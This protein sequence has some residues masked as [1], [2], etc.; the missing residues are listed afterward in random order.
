MGLLCAI[1][2][3]YLCRRRL[4]CFHLRIADADADI[5]VKHENIVS[6]PLHGRGTCI[7]TAL[8]SFFDIPGFS[9]I[10]SSLYL[11]HVGRSTYTTV[12]LIARQ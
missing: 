2:A 6:P 8:L 5:E 9:P 10:F 7:I 4:T 3:Y 12:R 11:S 1:A